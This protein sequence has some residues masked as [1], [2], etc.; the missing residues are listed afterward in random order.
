M[1]DVGDAPG[2]ENASDAA[3]AVRVSCSFFDSV[4]DRRPRPVTTSWA[5][6]ADRLSTVDPAPDADSKMDL[7]AWSPTIYVKGGTR[8]SKNVSAV[9][10]LV[11]DY[12]DGTTI[13]Q[14]RRAWAPW[15]H[16]IHTSWSH[17]PDAPR[18][19]VV[20]SFADPVPAKDWPAV[21]AWAYRRAPT[22]DKACK[23]A[24]RIYFL[25]ARPSE[26]SPWV[27]EVHDGP[28]L[29]V[30]DDMMQPPDPE[31]AS[32]GEARRTLIESEA[33]REWAASRLGA[34]VVGEPPRADHIACPSCGDAS[35]WFW[36]RPGPQARAECKHRNSCGWRGHLDELLGDPQDEPVRV[37]ASVEWSVIGAVRDLA[38]RLESGAAGDSEFGR[39][40]GDIA[41]RITPSMAD[42]LADD[43]A[44]ES[45]LYDLR[46]AAAAADDVRAVGRRVD[47]LTDRVRR[48]AKT[49][50]MIHT[51]RKVEDPEIFEHLDTREDGSVL[52]TLL[53]IVRIFEHDG[54]WK[55]AL[56]YDEF[57]A[58]PVIDDQPIADHLETTA[59]LWLGE[60]W[61]IHVP[62]TKVAEALDTVSRRRPRHS[63]REW[64][65]SLEW[66]GTERIDRLLPRYFDVEPSPLMSILGARWMVSAV[67]R[68]APEGSGHS[69]EGGPGCKVDTMLVLVGSQ[70]AGK[71]TGLKALAG[72]D[73]F[74]DSELRVGDKDAYMQLR[75]AW[76]YEA[77]EIDG[78]SKR[79][80]AEVKAFLSSAVDH[81]RPS[82][83]RHV[84]EQP[85]Q[86]VFAG[87]TNRED[88]LSDP[89]GSR[90]YWPAVVGSV[91][92]EAIRR[93]RKQ[94]WAEAVHR[95]RSGEVWHLSAAESAD[96]AA[97]SDAHRESDEWDVPVAAF[98]SKHWERGLTVGDILHGALDIPPSRQE[99]RH[100]MRLGK[101]LASRG[102]DKKRIRVSSGARPTLWFPMGELPPEHHI[103]WTGEPDGGRGGD[104]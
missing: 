7:A 95:Y 53:N 85:R 38:R 75:G 91:D 46:E 84:I 1:T 39:E 58:V 50:D 24:G 89:T 87:T 68:V 67:A 92:V 43:P 63:I 79:E 27:G 11:L 31:R 36:I 2:L 32:P 69:G 88:F 3:S 51:P 94:L 22:I 12:D 48:Y 20:V 28:P 30:T 82:Y 47:F 93:D 101:L 23:D 45:A 19:R 40:A 66:D 64:L 96:L 16:A 10:C 83:G 62:T 73:W 4:R 54:R 103:G 25:P 33:A 71:S 52:P 34:E 70:G 76:I 49:K 74:R 57:R 100:Q 17:K 60:K 9:T 41:K 81:Y 56:H 44:W 80:Q 37:P 65:W 55:D 61:G 78:W 14:A 18:F 6:L 98:L 8:G 104:A 90:R 5:K 26:D 59:A 86:C 42:R 35:V 15:A 77:A 13:E 72:P 97:V 29:R 99:R 21:W 102:Y